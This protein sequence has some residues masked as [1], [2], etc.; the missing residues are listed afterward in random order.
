ML[1]KVLLTIA[2]FWTLL[3][4]YIII[5]VDPDDEKNKWAMYSIAVYLG[6]AL[7]TFV[8]SVLGAIWS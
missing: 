2:F 1:V 3:N 4:V 5:A 8:I 7:A 6:V